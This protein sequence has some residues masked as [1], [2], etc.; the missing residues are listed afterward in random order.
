MIFL[1]EIIVFCNIKVF[2]EGFYELHIWPLLR[3]NYTYK[4]SAHPLGNGFSRALESRFQVP[5]N[6]A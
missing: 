3:E 5:K 6:E 2:L 4:E 1:D